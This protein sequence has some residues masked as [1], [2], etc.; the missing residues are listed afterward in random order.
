MEERVIQAS[1]VAEKTLSTPANFGFG[2]EHGGSHNARTMMLN[3]L[4][5]LFQCVCDPDAEKSAYAHAIVDENCLG[6]RSEKT[7][8]ITYRHLAC[9][10]GLDKSKV[11]FRALRYFWERDEAGRP[12]LALLACYARDSILRATAPFVLEQPVGASVKREATEAYIESV[13][14]GRFSKATLKSTAQNVNGT[15][16]RSGYLQGKARKHRVQVEPTAGSVAYAL[17]LAYLS[18]QRGA[19]LFES[20]YIKL[21]DCSFEKAIERAEEA[22]RRGWIVFKRIGEVMEVLFPNLITAEEMEWVREQ[23]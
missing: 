13:M 3:E 15:W 4:T 2:T 8:K 16:T 18:G 7:R 17:L 12:Q 10:Y 22:S 19:S 11:L 6:K 23:G 21:L 20:Q 1:T 14:P 9:L 5:T